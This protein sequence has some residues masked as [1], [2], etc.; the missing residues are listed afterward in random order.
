MSLSDGTKKEWVQVSNNLT[1]KS[2]L[3]Y[4]KSQFVNLIVVSGY[5]QINGLKN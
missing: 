2:H 1:I 3:I 5:F 4:F